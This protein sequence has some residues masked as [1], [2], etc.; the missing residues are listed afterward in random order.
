MIIYIQIVI[1]HLEFVW[2][3]KPFGEKTAYIYYYYFEIITTIII[4]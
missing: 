1:V 4:K 3:K 2:Y